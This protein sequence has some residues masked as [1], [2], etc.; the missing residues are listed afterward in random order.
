M[1]D[2]PL[3]LSQ[4]RDGE[5]R[6]VWE[7]VRVSRYYGLQALNI[8]ASPGNVAVDPDALTVYFFVPAGTTQRWQPMPA[9]GGLTVITDGLQ[10]PPGTRRTPPGTYWLVPPRQGVIRSCDSTALH[11]AL[12]ACLPAWTGQPDEQPNPT[13]SGSSDG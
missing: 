4:E 11:S 10:L 9:G 2:R 6:P 7:A 3:A 1:L 13:E 8:L 12:L 5:L